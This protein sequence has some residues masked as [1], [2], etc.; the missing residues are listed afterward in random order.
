MCSKLSRIKYIAR[1]GSHMRC[2]K[3][4]LWLTFEMLD[5]ACAQE[6]KRLFSFKTLMKMFG[7]DFWV[8]FTVPIWRPDLG[9]AG[10]FMSLLKDG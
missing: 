3:R 4:V 2:N 8:L 7:V 1:F 10:D 5:Y 6:A 9:K